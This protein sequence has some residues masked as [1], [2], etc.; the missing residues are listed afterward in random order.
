MKKLR[1]KTTRI[2]LLM[3]LSHSCYC[4]FAIYGLLCSE[5]FNNRTVLESSSIS[6]I[7]QQQNCILKIEHNMRLR[8]E[9]CESRS[10]F[11]REDP[12]VCIG[13][14]RFDRYPRSWRK[15][16]NQNTGIWA[17]MN[18]WYLTKAS[19]IRKL[20]NADTSFCPS[21]LYCMEMRIKAGKKKTER[22]A[23]NWRRS[24]RRALSKVSE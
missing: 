6:K 19:L 15:K 10:L 20:S 11:S 14:S 24:N 22:R 3:L 8:T 13:H 12:R 4:F 21:V 9:S 17:T 18:S 16:S 2:E 5:F 7:E 1:R 23:L